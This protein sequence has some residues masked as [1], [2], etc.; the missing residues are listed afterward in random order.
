MTDRSALLRVVEGFFILAG[1]FEI[2][3]ETG[4]FP[5][6]IVPLGFVKRTR[7]FQN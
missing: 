5:M 4:N 6:V 2:I 7:T 1:G 3:A